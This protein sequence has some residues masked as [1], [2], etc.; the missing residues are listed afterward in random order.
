MVK[1]VKTV[2]CF[3]INSGEILLIF[4]NKGIGKG[5]W[6]GPGGRLEKGERASECVI[7]ELVE[8][9]GIKPIKPE[10]MGFVEFYLDQEK[11]PDYSA[12]VFRAER[13]SGDL[14]ETEEA[15]PKWFSL[16]NIPYEKMFA[17]DK[18]HW[19]PLVIQRKAFK[20]KF[21]FSNNLEHIIK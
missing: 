20:G 12:Y 10:R 17:A 3:I 9:T 7:R 5:L 16:N 14:K 19:I 11:L 6:N 4:K 18:Q 15:R 8:E 21:Y 2:I 13:F 1:T